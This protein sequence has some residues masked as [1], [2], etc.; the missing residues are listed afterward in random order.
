V[1]VVSPVAG[2]ET[3]AARQIRANLARFS[4][5]QQNVTCPNCRYTG[6]VGFIREVKPFYANCFVLALLFLTVV[7]IVVVLL[8]AI[9]GRLRSASEVECPQCGLRFLNRS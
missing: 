6:P 8:L 4:A 9:L 1:P 3:P 7:G 5:F 2:A